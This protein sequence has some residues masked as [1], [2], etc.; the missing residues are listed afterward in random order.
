MVSQESAGG[1][2]RDQELRLAPDA[3]PIASGNQAF[4]Q[5]GIAGK[6]AV[7]V[8]QVGIQFNR[9]GNDHAIKRVSVDVRQFNGAD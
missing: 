6:V 9:R 2:I 3:T 1:G 4:C 5:F 8:S 7:D